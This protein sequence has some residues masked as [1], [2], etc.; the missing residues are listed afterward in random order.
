MEAYA[1]QAEAAL[2][3]KLPSITLFAL[4]LWLNFYRIFQIKQK[5]PHEL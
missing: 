3:D 2:N 5:I 1:G 4:I